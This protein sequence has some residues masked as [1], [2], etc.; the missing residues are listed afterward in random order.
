[1]KK[2][3]IIN[4]ILISLAALTGCATASQTTSAIP[5]ETVVQS[6]LQALSRGESSTCLALLADDVVFQQEPA[7]L[8]TEGKSQL[9]EAIRRLQ[10][11]HHQYEIIG[12]TVTSGDRVMLTV[13]EKADEYNIL[14]MDSVTAELDIR[15][16]NSRI[17]SWTSTVSRE[18][19]ER[20]TA[21]TA[22]RIGIKFEI[23]TQGA[24][25]KEVASKSPAGE[26]GIRPGDII[27]GVNGIDCAHMRDGEMQLRVQGPVGSRVTLKVTREGVST[28]FEVEISRA[29]SEDIRW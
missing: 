12:N 29:P 17:Q 6:F 5:P 3:S 20:L 16:V 13:R 25:V 19:W 15:V 18:D 24:R 4:V 28:P 10:A 26:A 23:S 21:L 11:W 8:K 9:D 2:L 7:G 14:G 27:T 1:M 22:G